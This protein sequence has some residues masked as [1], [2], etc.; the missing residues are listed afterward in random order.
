MNKD[1][2]S[3]ELFNDTLIDKTPFLTSAMISFSEKPA[4]ASDIL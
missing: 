3:T 2:P 1:A 4:S